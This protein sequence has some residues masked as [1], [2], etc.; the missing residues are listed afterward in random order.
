MGADFTER[1][2]AASFNSRCRTCGP[3]SRGAMGLGGRTAAGCGNAGGISIGLIDT[4]A[5]GDWFCAP[6]LVALSC[7]QAHTAH[8][9]ASRPDLRCATGGTYPFHTAHSAKIA[10][11][12]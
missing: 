1:Q 6:E 4:G 5:G 2:H 7:H 12:A 3:L 10:H 9:A 8:R 11:R